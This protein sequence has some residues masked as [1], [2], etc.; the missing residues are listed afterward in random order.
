MA[1]PGPFT[2]VANAKQL[3]EQFAPGGPLQRLLGQNLRDLLRRSAE[4]WERE[5]KTKQ[6]K[7]YTGHA[8]ARALQTRTGTL[9]R[10]IKFRMSGSGLNSAV[11]MLSEGTDYGRIQELGGVIKGKP[12]LRIPLQ[13]TLRNTGTGVRPEY[14]TVKRGT[15][16][17]TVRGKPTWVDTNRQGTPVIY[18]EGRQG[19]PEAIAVLKRSVKL[20]KG[21]FGFYR[22]WNRLAHVRDR[23]KKRALRATVRGRRFT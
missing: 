10:S 19:K 5:M 14:Q 1:T 8:R 16:W 17:T 20:P 13:H 22:T 7:A 11:T 18:R 3:A 21:R 2:I 23:Y 4:D 12:W 6:F 9:R 15:K